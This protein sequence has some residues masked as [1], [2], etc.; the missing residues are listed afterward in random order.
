MDSVN[1]YGQVTNFWSM[2]DRIDRMGWDGFIC[3]VKF[4]LYRWEDEMRG[5]EMKILSFD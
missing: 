3:A 4:V 5:V 2:L 1:G